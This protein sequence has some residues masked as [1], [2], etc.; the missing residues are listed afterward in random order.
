MVMIF[1]GPAVR[2]PRLNELIRC[3]QLERDGVR[4]MSHLSGYIAHG[5]ENNCL[6]S[7]LITTGPYKIT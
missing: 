3:R 7:G 1:K 2:G 6:F 5:D 4:A